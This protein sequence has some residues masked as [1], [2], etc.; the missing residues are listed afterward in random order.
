MSVGI[1]N[2]SAQN[3]S[4]LNDLDGF[5]NNNTSQTNQDAKNIYEDKS[6]ALNKDVKNFVV[7]IPN[8]AHESTNQDEDQYPFLNQAYIPQDLTINKGTSVTWLNGDVDHDHVIKFQPGNP[9]NLVETDQF[10]FPEY[11]TI[12]FNQTGSY[13]Y[14]EDN[15]NEND[16]SFVMEGTINVVDSNTENQTTATANSNS[17]QNG[18]STMGVLMVPSQDFENIKSGLENSGI[19]VLSDY[20]FTDL[21][22]GQEGTGPT[23]SILVWSSNINNIENAITP[24]VDLTNG[25]PYS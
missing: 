23:Q 10:A 22:G 25:L 21:R 8:E 5:V 7:L 14:Y 15:V 6:F 11:T 4:D 3:S 12:V 16:E 17:I 20:S 2:L 18:E 19:R 9:Q 13:S 1:E 24:I